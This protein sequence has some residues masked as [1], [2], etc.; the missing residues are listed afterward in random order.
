MQKRSLD[1]W[2]MLCVVF[3][4]SRLCIASDSVDVGSAPVKE[5]QNKKYSLYLG[6][7]GGYTAGY[8]LSARK[9]FNNT[10]ALQLNMFPYYTQEDIGPVQLA[11]VKTDSG[12]KY[13][14]DLSVGMIYLRKL[15]DF[16]YGRMV[17]YAGGNLLTH[18]ENYDYSEIVD[19]GWSY[20]S[21][22]TEWIEH[23]S[24]KVMRNKITIG[25]GAGS[26]FYIWRFALHIMLGA[27]AGYT[28]ETKR[29]SVL[30]S[31]EG[32]IQFRL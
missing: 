31:V 25:G 1:M 9:W 32:G 24:G 5:N 3:L 14:G 22:Y 12:Y 13:V 23:R 28:V 20:N 29:I 19:S 16:R 27:C 26:E 2:K 4:V 18:Y 21:T 15:A 10:W 7:A 8:G 11:G 6:I 30:P 17:W